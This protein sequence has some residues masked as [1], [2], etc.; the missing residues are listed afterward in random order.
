MIVFLFVKTDV[1]LKY[2][3]ENEAW[4]IHGTRDSS[5]AWIWRWYPLKC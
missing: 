1:L 4:E 2:I 5:S 3:A